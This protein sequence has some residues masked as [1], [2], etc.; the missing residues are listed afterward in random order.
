ML[1][2]NFLMD[3]YD[4]EFIN[5]PFHKDEGSVKVLTNEE[6][7]NM[8]KPVLH[9]S[10]DEENVMNEIGNLLDNDTKDS[11]SQNQPSTNDLMHELNEALSDDE[12]DRILM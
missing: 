10:E 9:N 4:E 7:K 6:I 1:C 8:K 5:D 12:S 11:S 2:D 3:E